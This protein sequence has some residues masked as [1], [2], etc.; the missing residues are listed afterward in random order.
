M[1]KRKNVKE[2]GK[3]NV[4]NQNVE[5]QT[6]E[7]VENSENPEGENQEVNEDDSN[8]INQPEETNDQDGD[9]DN[10][11]DQ[12]PGDNVVIQEEVK[13]KMVEVIDKLMEVDDLDQLKEVAEGA[14]GYVTESGVDKGEKQRLIGLVNKIYNERKEEI[15]WAAVGTKVT[16]DLKDFEKNLTGLKKSLGELADVFKKEFERARETDNLNAKELKE[17]VFF[18]RAYVK[19]L[20]TL[21]VRRSERL[22]GTM[23]KSKNDYLDNRNKEIMKKSKLILKRQDLTGKGSVLADSL[24]E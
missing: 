19:A 23:K 22:T 3:E 5:N 16:F 11:G 20:K 15:Y 10:A 4:E 8:Q 9:G 2:D 6:E 21:G 1:A 13:N 14:I 7:V 12:G 24:G 18:Y 17:L